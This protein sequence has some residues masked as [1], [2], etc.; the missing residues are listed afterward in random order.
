MPLVRWD[1][2]AK[3]GQC[4]LESILIK[5][6]G[7]KT[8]NWWGL[9]N[10][11]EGRG[12]R[13]HINKYKVEAPIFPR[14]MRASFLCNFFVGVFN[15][16]AKG[17]GGRNIEKVQEDSWGKTRPASVNFIGHLTEEIT[18]FNFLNV[19]NA[20]T[21]TDSCEQLLFC[22]EKYI[23]PAHVRRIH[24]ARANFSSRRFQRGKYD[25]L[26]LSKLYL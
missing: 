7:E 19:N 5:S 24:A 12:L 18:K 4:Q 11:R 13:E 10:F 16:A 14:N 9:I 1:A 23:R 6:I 3:S 21:R 2:Q 22:G 15:G 25:K 17:C 8:I 26:L 20:R